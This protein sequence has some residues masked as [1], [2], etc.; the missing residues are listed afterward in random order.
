MSLL[1]NGGIAITYLSTTPFSL[2]K[3]ISNELHNKERLAAVCQVNF[4][5]FLV[6]NNLGHNEELQALLDTYNCLDSISPSNT[7][8]R[9]PDDSLR[10]NRVYSLFLDNSEQDNNSESQ[11]GLNSSTGESPEDSVFSS[12]FV[13]VQT[14]QSL[15]EEESSSGSS[16]E[17]IESPFIY[18]ASNSTMGHPS[19]KK[20][21]Y[22]PDTPSDEGNIFLKPTASLRSQRQKRRSPSTAKRETPKPI[23]P[24]RSLSASQ[25][26]AVSSPHPLQSPFASIPPPVPASPPSKLPPQAQPHTG[27]KTP[28]SVYYDVAGNQRRSPPKIPKF[29][30]PEQGEATMKPTD[31]SKKKVVQ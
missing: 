24:T 26:D 20:Q 5:F 27:P 15:S 23:K 1:L 30:K 12:P 13:L 25:M 29:L 16:Q 9:N 18:K 22:I 8:Q 10:S 28:K 11:D 21:E 19:H 17:F 3:L 4:V 6:S 7:Q 2:P 14:Q 31:L